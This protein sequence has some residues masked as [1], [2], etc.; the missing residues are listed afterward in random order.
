MS[1]LEVKDVQDLQVGSFVKLEGSWFSH[2]FPTNMFLIKSAEDLATIQGLSHVT[3][4]Y[5]PDR[6]HFADSDDDRTNGEELLEPAEESVEAETLETSSMEDHGNLQEDESLISVAALSEIVG[7]R[8]DYHE[9]YDHLQK[10][11]GTYKKTLS[12]G[13]ELFQQLSGR[14][15]AGL[16]T[17]DAMITDMMQSLNNPKTAMSLIDLVG[18]NG[19][20]W[21]LSEHAMNVCTLSLLI[22]RQFSLE[23]DVLLEL[24]RGALFHDVGY[25]ALPMNVKFQARGMKVEANPELR[26]LHPELGSK[27]H[28]FLS[29]CWS[30]VDR[31]YCTPS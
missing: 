14:R 16:K 6:S 10:V 13:Q 19:V 3:I 22:G 4:L 27:T 30:I 8:E 21:G 20:T 12:Q 23:D 11:E 18:S 9:F 24:G 15:P 25:R 31:N 1:F 28:G 7:R 26:V 17:G 2:P 5:D 29:Q